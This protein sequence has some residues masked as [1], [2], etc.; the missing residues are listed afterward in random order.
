MVCASGTCHYSAGVLYQR[1]FLLCVHHLLFLYS[2]S[3][4]EEF[5]KILEKLLLHTSEL[6]ESQKTPKTRKQNPSEKH[7]IKPK[8]NPNLLL[9]CNFLPD[10]E[11]EGSVYSHLIGNFLGEV[12][13]NFSLA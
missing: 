7:Q 1:S 13:W 11:G 9:V 6:D 12:F 3:S 5:P 10:L 2:L 8:K 4:R